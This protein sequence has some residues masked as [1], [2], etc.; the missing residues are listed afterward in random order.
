V[1][2]DVGTGDGRAVLAAA[3]RDPRTLAIGID[4]SPAGLAEA[5]RRAAAPARK[6]GI[7]NAA[8]IVASAASLP[9]ALTGI[10][11]LVT[12]R[13]PWGSLLRGSL[14]R[15]ERVAA[16]I[17]ALVGPAGILEL[18]LA[19]AARDGLEGIPTDTDAIIAAATAA[20]DAHGLARIAARRATDAEI[21]AS[22]STWARRLGKDRS[23]VLIRLGRR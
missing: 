20:F 7:P 11:Q 22:G 19:P 12:V 16:G 4:S 23:A 15:D 2:I 17:A 8:F 1:T 10:A 18:L 9:D 3:R 14:G 5:S 6:G 13:F 21:E